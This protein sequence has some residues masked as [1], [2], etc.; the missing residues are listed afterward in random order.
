MLKFYLQFSLLAL[1]I[2]ATSSCALIFESRYQKIKIDSTPQ[3]AEIY[4]MGDYMG[5]TPQV[6]EFKKGALSV[7]IDLI[8]HGFKPSRI[9]LYSRG[10]DPTMSTLCSIDYTFG[11]L[12]LGVPMQIDKIFTK[13]CDFF[14][15]NN[16]NEELIPSD[17]IIIKTT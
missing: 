5:K 6:I 9:I 1:T 16:F 8:K 13:K 10:R 11:W 7:K 14:Y 2:F 3:G 4:V 12:L 17:A 15:K